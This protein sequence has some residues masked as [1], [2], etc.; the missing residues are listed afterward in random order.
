MRKTLIFL[1]AAL[2]LLPILPLLP[3]AAESYNPYL[4]VNASERLTVADVVSPRYA[5]DGSYIA[6]IAK[7]PSNTIVYAQPD[8]SN[9]HQIAFISNP[10]WSLTFKPD[11]AKLALIVAT[12]GKESGTVYTDVV[13]VGAD[14]KGVNFLTN[15]TNYN[16]DPYFLPD[17]RIAYTTQQADAG[18]YQVWVMQPDGSEQRIWINPGLEPILLGVS[19]TRDEVLFMGKPSGS[20]I[21][22][23]FLCDLNAGNVRQITNVEGGAKAGVFS[24]DGERVTFVVGES[25]QEDLAIVNRDGSNPYRLSTMGSSLWRPSWSPDGQFVLFPALDSASS[26]FRIYVVRPD[27]QDLKVLSPDFLPSVTSQ[28]QW[29]PGGWSEVIFLA[30]GDEGTNNIWRMKLGLAVPVPPPPPPPVE[31]TPTPTPSATP[32]PVNAAFSDIVGHWAEK[33]IAQLKD[34]GIIQGYPDGTFRPEN[35]L[36]R[37]EFAAFLLRTLGY[38]E[39]MDADPFFA[40]VPGSYWGFGTIQGLVLKHIVARDTNFY[41]EDKITRLEIIQWEVRALDLEDETVNRTI[42]ALPFSDLSDLTELEQKY[43][44]TAYELQLISGYPDGSLSPWGFATR[45]EATALLFRLMANLP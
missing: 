15:S 31:V 36:K 5:P 43:V 20:S 4:V 24:P 12:T 34:Q 33:D 26:K 42:P 2:L 1:L 14:G 8:G 23:L 17:G 30:A 40:D 35:T 41:P 39:V 13:T 18:V 6:F 9:Q 11:G 25:G 29:Q 32:P 28:V 38:Q 45:A 16:S 7:G 44:A 19:P 3:A 21:Y 22:Q 10:I 27:G 37:V